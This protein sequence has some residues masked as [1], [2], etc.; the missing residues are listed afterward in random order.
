M[1]KSIVISGQIAAGTTTAAKSIS[2]KLN[3]PYHSAGDFFRKYMLEHKIPLHA[4]DKIPDDL[5]QKIDQSL[6]DLTDSPAGVIIDAHYAGYFNREKPEVLKV[7][8]T[9]D[10]D[11]RIKRATS[12]VHTHT[13]TADDI[14]KREEGLDAKFRKLY[15]NENFLDP[16]FFDLIID[17]TNTRAEDVVEQIVKKWSLSTMSS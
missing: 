13:E 7:L 17:T 6:S 12:R 9:C 1:Y 10:Q 8:L 3:L 15:A 4:K 14:K 16:K 2:E 5:E 11:E